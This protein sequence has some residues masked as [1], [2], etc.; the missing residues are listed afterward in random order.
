M[1]HGTSLRGIV[2]HLDNMSNEEI[3][4]L[5]LPTTMPFV[6]TLNQHMKPIE[7]GSLQFLGNEE[8]VKKAMEDVKNQIK[9][10]KEITK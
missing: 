3:R 7:G 10:K 9:R 4:N 8:D 5:N 6:Y 1:A 2:K